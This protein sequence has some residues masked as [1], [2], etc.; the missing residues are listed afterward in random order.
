M[1]AAGV[2]R[3]LRCFHVK[4]NFDYIIAVIAEGIWGNCK[5]PTKNKHEI[6]KYSN[7][8]RFPHTDMKMC[9][10]AGILQKIGQTS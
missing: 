10:K 7:K 3:F 2:H 5:I 6:N 9:I 1:R 4:N 8:H